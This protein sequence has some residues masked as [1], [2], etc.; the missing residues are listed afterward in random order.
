MVFRSVVKHFMC[1]GV[2]LFSNANTFAKNPQKITMAAVGDIIFHGDL[3][4]QAY[5]QSSRSNPDFSFLWRLLEEHIE[6]VDLMYGNLEGPSRS[7]RPYSDDEAGTSMSFNFHPNAISNL[8][9][10]GFDIF[11]TA[12]NHSLDQ[13]NAGIDS[14]LE[15]LDSL[16]VKHFGMVHSRSGESVSNSYTTVN[17]NGI[18]LAF[19]GCAESLNGNIDRNQQVLRCYINNNPNPELL[20]LIERLHSRSD[21]NGIIFSPH[22]GDEYVSENS[23]QRSL[24]R[25]AIDAG[26]TVVLGHH[27]H[28]LQSQELYKG[29]NIFYSLGN[30]ISNQ[31][32]Q[33]RTYSRNGHTRRHHKRMPRR[34]SAIVYLNFELIGNKASVVDWK[35]MPIYMKTKY[36]PDFDQNSTS[37][38]YDQ[39]NSFLDNI[40]GGTISHRTLI[41]VYIPEYTG[42]SYENSMIRGFDFFKERS[43]LSSSQRSIV[44]NGNY[45]IAHNMKF[46][47][48]IVE[49]VFPKDKWLTAEEVANPELI[50]QE[51]Q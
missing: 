25:V 24:A 36:R 46:A 50:F 19:V 9:E 39:M 40:Y 14:T 45:S 6:S 17:K 44:T 8:V 42:V 7:D 15:L 33:N 48:D 5:R 30:F 41:P 28:V 21:I 47:Q 20:T 34:S 16:D 2:L 35:V 29:K 22:W 27:P 37:D 10:S 12:N 23:K 51:A 4:K 43:E 13:G 32:P 11:S 49:N 1:L 3:H 18:N 38:A 31:F 26:A